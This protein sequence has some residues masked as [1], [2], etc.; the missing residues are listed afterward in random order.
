M[1]VP[2][3]FRGV[4]RGLVVPLG[5]ALAAASPSAAAPAALSPDEARAIARDAYV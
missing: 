3:F 1:S 4:L 5:L 2:S